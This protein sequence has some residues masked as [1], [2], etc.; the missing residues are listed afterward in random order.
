MTVKEKIA[1][2]W[3]ETELELKKVAWPTREEMIGS[4]WATIVISGILAIFVWAVDIGVSQAVIKL[5][6]IL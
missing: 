6:G 5:F 2:Y 3:S 4:T 1:K